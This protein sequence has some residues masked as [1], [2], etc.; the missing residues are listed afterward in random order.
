MIF[1]YILSFWCSSCI[2][3][4][5]LF[6]KTIFWF[7]NGIMA[8]RYIIKQYM[9]LNFIMLCHVKY[10]II[11]SFEVKVLHLWSHDVELRRSIS[12]QPI[13]SNPKTMS[14]NIQIITIKVKLS[15]LGTKWKLLIK[16]NRHCFALLLRTKVG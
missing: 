3:W 7:P 14:K 8:A 13:A 16:Y 12:C 6:L 4:A 5:I 2:G 9:Y 1:V 10:G 11:I 15:D